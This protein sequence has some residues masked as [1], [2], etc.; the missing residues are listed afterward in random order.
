MLHV[1]V[2]HGDGHNGCE[3][4]YLEGGR[5]NC[6]QGHSPW[7]WRYRRK[8]AFSGFRPHRLSVSRPLPELFKLKGELDGTGRDG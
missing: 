3:G 4:S 8:P 2:K 1:V 7:K 5:G 6:G